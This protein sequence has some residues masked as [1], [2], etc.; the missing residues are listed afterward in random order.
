MR[1][2]LVANVAKEHVRKF[3]IP[4]IAFMKEQGHTVDVACRMDEPIPE[5]DTAFDLPC[6]RNPFNGGLRKSIKMLRKI[7]EDNNYDVVICNTLTGSIIA[8]GAAIFLGKKM[9][10]LY[11]I[12]HGL[13]FFEGAPVTRWII[14]Y[15]TE[16]ILSHFTDTIITIN[17]ADYLMAKKRLKAKEVLKING[18]GCDL[19]YFRGFELTEE[20]RHAL[21]QS[22][23][24]DDDDLMLV[25]VA[26]IND[27]KNQMM[28]VEAFKRVKETISNSKLVLVGPEHDSEAIRRKISEY[29]LEYDVV[30]T[31]W[32]DDIAALLKTSDIYV[33]S[34]K[35]EG[36]PINIL[37]AMAC[38]LPVVAREN[39]GHNEI[40]DNG[41]NGFIV[42][43][44]DAVAMAERIIRLA[45]DD[46]L[47]RD[48]T[49]Q[50]QLDIE[51]Y[52]IDNVV[53]QIRNILL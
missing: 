9:P 38:G 51:K 40:I 33:A 42:A 31:G 29:K 45:N 13:H 15:P 2:L 5:C 36:L 32:R 41:S 46:D 34:S 44:E 21:R 35:S 48:F 7:I 16:W 3:H 39:R 19:G 37:E 11:Y 25:Y 49:Q 4:Y 50:G 1:I 24:V 22:F 10:R 47:R 27:N 23:G 6:N 52:C 30:F 8:R 26:E 28:L 43:K 12:V 18:I 53:H 17:E 14:G 20:A